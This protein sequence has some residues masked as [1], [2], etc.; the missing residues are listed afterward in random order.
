MLQSII[1]GLLQISF[2]PS[3]K[4]KGLFQVTPVDQ[5]PQCI[6]W[7]PL[8]AHLELMIEVFSIWDVDTDL[9]WI[10]LQLQICQKEGWGQTTRSAW[11]GALHKVHSS[12]IPYHA[13]CTGI[14]MAIE[15]THR[16]V[17]LITWQRLITQEK[18]SSNIPQLH[19]SSNSIVVFLL[20]IRNIIR[21]L[22]QGPS[23]WRRFTKCHPKWIR[24]KLWSIPGSWT[25]Q[26]EPFWVEAAVWDKLRGPSLIHRNMHEGS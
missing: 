11:D 22:T 23:E 1:G 26:P 19:Q 7:C 10:G 25:W 9:L 20:N 2:T 18:E 8:S 4:R 5:G 17:C 15:E 16:E 24:Q 12:S 13:V 14:L 6:W 21:P 3:R